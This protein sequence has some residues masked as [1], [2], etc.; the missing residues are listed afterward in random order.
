MAGPPGPASAF[1]LTSAFGVFS[2]SEVDRS[3]PEGEPMAPAETVREVIREL[4]AVLF[5]LDTPAAPREPAARILDRC[6]E[7][8]NEAAEQV[9]VES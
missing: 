6:S 9:R 5:D 4:H 2:V 3:G 7:E 1:G 8:L